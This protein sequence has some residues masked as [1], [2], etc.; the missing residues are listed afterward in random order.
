M[1]PDPLDA[2]P[3][4]KAGR[5]VGTASVDRRRVAILSA[6]GKGYSRLMGEDEIGTVRTLTAYRTLMRDAVARVAGR[7][8]DTPG[9]NLL[10]EFASA[11]DA[12]R[13]AVEIQEALRERNAELPE[14]RRLEFRIGVN[15]G[16]VIDDGEYLYGDTVNI[17]ARLEAMADGGGLCVSGIVHDQVAPLLPLTWE[18]LGEQAV[19]NIA[20]PVRVYRARLAMAGPPPSREGL[21]RPARRPSIAVLPFQELGVHEE[22]RYFGD[23]IM[24]DVVGA[25]AS[26]P[27]L[28]VIS[29]NSTSRF[30]RGADDVRSVGRELAVRYVLSG[31]VRRAGERLRITA[32]LADS[33]TQAILWTDKIDGRVTDLFDLQ[34]RLSE[35][36]ITTIAPHVRQAELRRALRERPENLDAYDFMLRGL[37]LLYR[38]SRK[39]FELAREMLERAIALDP[40]YA[41]PYTL[42]ALWHSI[43]VGQGWS[44]DPQADYAEVARFAE[45]ALARDPVDPR[46]LA[47]YGHLKALLFHDYEGALALFDRAIAVSPNSAVAWGRSSPTYSYI[48]D[49]TEAKRRATIAL[50]LSPLDPHLF[51]IHTA[52]GLACY[53][54][55]DYEAA[56]SWCRKAMAQNPNYTANL[57]FLAASLAAGGR[58]PEAHGIARALLDI[59]PGFR[60][61]RFC[62]GY[63]YKDPAR[64]TALAS[65]L[66]AAGLPE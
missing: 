8:V 38:L 33:E 35:K 60:V 59:E 26:Q 11:V 62:D 25:I 1:R 47:L 56:A 48:G 27:D 10:A 20:R 49:A 53:T 24:E 7:V 19:K 65:H 66:G 14:G 57:R 34:D 28:F 9:D 52:L 13:C 21:L 44:Q 17:A 29:R 63:A 40:T 22:E 43:R 42:T 32:E 5:E 23:G 58:R 30:R 37:D 16:E 6:D 18:P 39:E 15:V 2:K 64:R 61:R 31:S 45:A 36:I 54:A 55:G 41:A 50:R 4:Q 51:L 12:V 46:A 3:R